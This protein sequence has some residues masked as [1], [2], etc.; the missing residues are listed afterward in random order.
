M[1]WLVLEV[2]TKGK[3]EYDP[4]NPIL[5]VTNALPVYGNAGPPPPPFKA[6]LAVKAYE[7]DKAWSAY[8]EVP[9]NE[10]VALN[11]PPFPIK[12]DEPSNVNREFPPKTPPLLYCTELTPTVPPARKVVTYEAVSACEA[13]SAQLAVP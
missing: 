9:S 2:I 10:P 4:V 6:K 5:P 7:L 12:T 1:V 13:L 8:E 11:V 3:L